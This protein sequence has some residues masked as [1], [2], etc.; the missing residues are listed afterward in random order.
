M[1]DIH[2]QPQRS[3]VEVWIG[4][5]S[6]DIGRM[7]ESVLIEGIHAAR[8]VLASAITEGL[9][10]HEEEVEFEHLHHFDSVE[11]CTSHL[12]AKDWCES[13]ADETLI[14]STRDLLSQGNAEIVIREP[15]RVARL[16]RLG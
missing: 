5:R 2:P 13:V 15:V 16:K 8:K 11:E 1:L 9:F 12:I 6:I 4:E 7:D 10:R 14:E 3:R